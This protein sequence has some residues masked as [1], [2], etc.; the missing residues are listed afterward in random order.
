MRALFALMIVASACCGLAAGEDE[1]LETAR[2]YYEGGDYYSAITEVMRYQ[3]LFPAGSGYARSMLLMGK[4]Y[5]RGGNY[6]A[7]LGVFSSCGRDFAGSPAGEEALYLSGYMQLEKGELSGAMIAAGEYRRRYPAG[8]FI[9]EMDR[10]ACF[11]AALS[12][13]RAGSRE[14]IR[15]YREKY[16]EGKYRAGL[17]RLEKTLDGDAARPQRYLW[18]SVLGSALIPGFGH[19]YTGHYTEGVLTLFSNALFIF[20]ICNAAMMNNTFQIVFFSLAEAVVY[21]YNLFSAV[22][23]VDEYNGKRER[24]FFRNVRLG[25]TASF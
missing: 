19:F 15:A 13:D 4:A 16:P 17:E 7:A 8:A 21:Q 3:F 1:V 12:R 14:H 6:R 10:D 24:D 9:E 5:Y 20:M 25:M 2:R 23:V 11:S 18:L 22:R